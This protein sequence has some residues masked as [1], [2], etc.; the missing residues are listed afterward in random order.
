MCLKPHHG[1][2]NKTP[3]IINFSARWKYVGPFIYY[4]PW[5][6]EML[7]LRTGMYMK[8]RVILDM[9]I[10]IPALQL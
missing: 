4:K 1:H 10:K 5:G 8:F 6:G 2:G 7:Y 9:V 3:H